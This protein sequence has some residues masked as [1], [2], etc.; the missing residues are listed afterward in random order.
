M[1]TTRCWSI[2]RDRCQWVDVW[3]G[4]GSVAGPPF[5][6]EECDGLFVADGVCAIWA[7]GRDDG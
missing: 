5:F 4:A 6:E 7:D 1:R 2:A 3:Q